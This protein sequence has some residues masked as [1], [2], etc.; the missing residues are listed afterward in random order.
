MQSSLCDRRVDEREHDIQQGN[1]ASPPSDRAHNQTSS[2]RD[3]LNDAI[4]WMHRYWDDPDLRTSFW[5]SGW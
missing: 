2:K 5:R 1:Y 3:L 4:D